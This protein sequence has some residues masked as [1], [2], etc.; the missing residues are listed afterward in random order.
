MFACGLI[1]RWVFLP[2]PPLVVIK[3]SG[4]QRYSSAFRR[5][6]IPTVKYVSSTWIKDLSMQVIRRAYLQSCGES[7]PENPLRL[8]RP[9]ST[10]DDQRGPVGQDRV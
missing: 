4:W 2:R 8:P 10:R 3:S 9:R 5:I 6:R 7:V 1:I